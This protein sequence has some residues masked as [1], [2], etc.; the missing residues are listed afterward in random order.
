MGT[1]QSGVLDLLIADL[2][3][4]GRILTESRAAA[5]QLLNEDPGLNHPDNANIRR[6]IESLP[7]T[8]V[9]WSRIS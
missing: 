2:A 4:D 8:A 3:K 9:N 6:H 7:A 1:Q 5:Q